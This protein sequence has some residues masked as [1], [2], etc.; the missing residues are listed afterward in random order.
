MARSLAS[1]IGGIG[2]MMLIKITK[3]SRTQRIEIAIRKQAMRVSQRQDPREVCAITE[4]PRTNRMTT[5]RIGR[6]TAHASIGPRR[7]G[8][9]LE[10]TQGI[11]QM[12]AGKRPS[13]V[14]NSLSQCE[15][16]PT[17]LGAMLACRL[18]VGILDSPVMDCVKILDQRLF[19]GT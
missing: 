3:Q 10:S 8:N 4:S 14:I 16:V 2:G 17:P 15:T 19:D 9:R 18:L 5:P 7:F 11:V 6:I 1:R 12:K 13:Q